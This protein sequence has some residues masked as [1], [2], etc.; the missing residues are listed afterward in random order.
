MESKSVLFLSIFWCYSSTEWSLPRP[1]V[2]AS[3][4]LPESEKL[5]SS[6]TENYLI[7]YACIWYFSWS[8]NTF[9]CFW[10]IM[11]EIRLPTKHNG[12]IME[13]ASRSGFLTVYQNPWYFTVSP[14]K[15]KNA[16][17]YVCDREVRLV[18]LAHFR[19]WV[20]NFILLQLHLKNINFSWF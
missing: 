1:P 9:G 18:W 14:E 16:T 10:S 5:F 7:N 19:E 12:K 8:C 20:S 11:T 13:F 6:G 15:T 17:K 2:G 4:C 3:L